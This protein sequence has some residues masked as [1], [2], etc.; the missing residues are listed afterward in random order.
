MPDTLFTTERLVL[1]R[2]RDGDMDL[3]LEHLNT[4]AVKAYLGGVQTREQV[5][6]RFARMVPAWDED[7]F[8]FLAVERRSD[9]VFLGTCGLAPIAGDAAPEPLASGHQVGW[10]IR[11]D[12]WGQGY[13][14]EA[15]RAMLAQAFDDL[16]WDVLYAQTSE[17]NTG[18]WRV[19]QRLGMER[20][21]DLDYVDEAY[22]PEDNP[23]MVWS[24]ARKDYLSR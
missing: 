7:G 23:T 15:A 10:Q 2:W 11:A 9:G 20:R 19:M 17:R 14:S 3:W 18:S 5:A 8:S 12:A 4:P 1:R 24:L 22:P 13:A 21:A 16:G 6:E